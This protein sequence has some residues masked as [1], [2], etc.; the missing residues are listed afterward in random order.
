MLKGL[1]KLGLYSKS[2]NFLSKISSS[3]RALANMGYFFRKVQKNKEFLKAT[4]RIEA[5]GVKVINSFLGYKAS[6]AKKKRAYITKK[7]RR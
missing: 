6:Q 1:S 4:K 7:L 3:L 5:Q 2:R